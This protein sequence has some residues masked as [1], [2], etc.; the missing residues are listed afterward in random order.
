M[1]VRWGYED[2]AFARG[3]GVD[4]A[5]ETVVGLPRSSLVKPT[6]MPLAM[7]LV[8]PPQVP[9]LEL[10]PSPLVDMPPPEEPFRGPYASSPS[11]NELLARAAARGPRRTWESLVIT[12]DPVLDEKRQP[13][14]AERRARLTRVVKATLGACLAVCVVA[15][16]VSALSRDANA[17]TAAS[18]VSAGKA[19]ASKA[20]VPIEPL[21][22]TKHG[23][24]V[25]RGA[26]TAPT[27]AIV[28]AKRR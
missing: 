28:R 14:V 17:S 10:A 1:G 23:K 24:A 12:S 6:T 19:V 25:R 8:A 15:I 3:R 27:A 21:D 7:P 16:G 18:P 26:T 13:H 4:I 22:G 9:I 20:V 11:A 5:D 2:P